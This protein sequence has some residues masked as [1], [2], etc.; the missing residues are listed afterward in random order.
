VNA[1]RE[2]R[3]QLQPGQ[4]DAVAVDFRSEPS[5]RALLEGAG[6]VEVETT[7]LEVSVTY[8][9]VDELW[10]PATHVGGPGGPAAERFSAEQLARGRDLFAQALGSPTG[11]FTLGGRAAAARGTRA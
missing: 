5:L 4:D 7:T 10:E 11:S 3:R 1:L 9:T 6:L 2:V 8:S